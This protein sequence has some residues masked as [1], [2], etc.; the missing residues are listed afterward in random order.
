[1][2]ICPV[3]SEGRSKVE[4]SNHQT[5]CYASFGVP[6]TGQGPPN[7]S[8]RK[9]NRIRT[10]LKRSQSKADP[11][12]FCGS[13]PPFVVTKKGSFLRPHWPNGGSSSG[14]SAEKG[15]QRPGPRQRRGSPLRRAIPWGSGRP[16]LKQWL[17][18]Y[19][20]A[21]PRFTKSP[22]HMAMPKYHWF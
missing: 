16:P 6:Q 22:V 3:T 10:L 17:G 11:S 19:G 1:M 5:C 4:V 13:L 15:K 14:A 21:N 8:G 20:H 7:T 9:G 18:S 2:S 12:T